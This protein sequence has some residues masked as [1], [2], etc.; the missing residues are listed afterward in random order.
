MNIAI[1]GATGNVGRKIIE[2]LYKKK[3]SVNEL[4]NKDLVRKFI[5]AKK[6]IKKGDQYT[7]NNLA[8]K[9]SGKKG[10]SP[11][12]WRKLIGKKSNKNYKKDQLIKIELSRK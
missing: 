4:K 1:V 3:I 2:V 5:V 7:T 12:E 6:D 8:F 11:M 10:I 9:R